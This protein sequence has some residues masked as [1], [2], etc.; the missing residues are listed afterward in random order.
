M[1]EAADNPFWDFSLALY[2]RGGVAEAC[3]ALQDRHGLDVNL[4][5]YCLWAGSRGHRL[6]AGEID[7]L[8]AAAGPWHEAVVEPLRAA[9]RWL[10][11][12]KSA[13]PGPAEALRQAIKAR[14]LEAEAIEQGILHDRMVIPPAEGTL[15]HGAAS[16]MAYIDFAGIHPDSEDTANLAVLLGACFP[17]LPPLDAVQALVR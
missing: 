1:P 10:K 13:P 2:R 11:D 16:L 17:D 4:L 6:D 7:A 3:L 15:R 5:L 9:R 14:E 12:Q 8:S